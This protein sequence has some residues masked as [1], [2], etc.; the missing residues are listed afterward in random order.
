MTDSLVSLFFL[1][2]LIFTFVAVGQRKIEKIILWAGSALGAFAGI[3]AFLYR[4]TD[5]KGT[6]ITMIRFN[7]WILVTIALVALVALLW[8]LICLVLRTSKGWSR[9]LGLLLLSLTVALS[10][11]YLTPQVLQY[12]QEFVYFGESGISTMALLRFIG[13][14]LGFL[15]CFLLSVSAA[16]V[17]K[18]FSNRARLLLLNLSLL[19]YS[20]DFGTRA[21]AALQRLKVL[22]LTDLVFEIMIFGDNYSSFFIF[23][24]LLL[25]LFMVIYVTATHRV[26]RQQFANKA[27]LRKEKARLRLFRRWSF[28][29]FLWGA[30]SV[31]TLVVLRWY[32]TKEPELAPPEEYTLTDGIISIPLDAV[33]DGHLHR[34]SFVTPNGYD[35]RFLAVKKPAG[36]AYGVGLDACEICGI[37]GYFERGDEVVCKRCDVVMNKNTIGFKGGCNPIPF[38]YEIKNMKIY[39]D[40]RELIHHEKRFR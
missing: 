11:L 9:G 40:T 35:V 38:P 1:F 10:L 2:G 5:P 17:Q 30:L 31:F 26:V 13:F 22:P 4:M 36:T 16:Q 29:L 37:A 19:I 32:Y 6:N 28:G 8:S 18:A 14:I 39:I 34:F 7:R 24:Q 15:L 3:G 23:A 12:T 25:A 21:V 27:L 20:L 33:S